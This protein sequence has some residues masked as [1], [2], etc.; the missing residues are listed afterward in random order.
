[1]HGSMSCNT[2]MGEYVA[3]IDIGYQGFGNAYIGNKGAS[4]R[5]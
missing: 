4:T 1:M 5:N 2:N 3:I